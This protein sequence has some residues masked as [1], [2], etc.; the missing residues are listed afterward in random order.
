MERKDPSKL[1]F[2]TMLRKYNREAKKDGNYPKNY[3]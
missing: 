1:H 3:P 2:I